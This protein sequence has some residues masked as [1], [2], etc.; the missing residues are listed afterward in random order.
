MGPD[1]HGRRRGRGLPAR[2][3]AARQRPGLPRR[4]DRQDLGATERHQGL[5]LPP[6]RHQTR[7]DCR[8]FRT[9]LLGD[10][11]GPRHRRRRPGLR[12]AAGLCGGPR[13]GGLPAVLAGPAVARHGHQRL[14]RPG[15]ARAG[16]CGHAAAR[17]ATGRHLGGRHGRWFGAP[18]RPRDCRPGAGGHHQ[19]RRG[20]AA[21]V[22]RRRGR[23]ARGALPA[24]DARRRVVPARRLRRGLRMPP[25]AAC[26]GHHPPRETP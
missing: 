14:A 8:V 15:A 13:T 21:L 18:A 7:P 17:R 11:P 3:H 12:V 10:A 9:Q 5:V 4:L 23:H 22:A 16:A 25:D 24:A 6:P 20:T 19:C 26:P 1:G 2:G